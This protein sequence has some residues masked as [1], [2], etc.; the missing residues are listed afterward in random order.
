[1]PAHGKNFGCGVDRVLNEVKVD[2]ASMQS[3]KCRCSVMRI[4]RRAT[5][6]NG[7]YSPD[8]G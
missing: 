6:V 2:L 7:G 1:M 5:V 8:K 4:T 3:T